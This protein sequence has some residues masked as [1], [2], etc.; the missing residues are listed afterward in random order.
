MN[1]YENTK[2]ESGSIYIPCIYLRRF[3][4]IFTGVFNL[5]LV[6]SRLFSWETNGCVFSTCCPY[7]SRESWA[8]EAA[9]V[10]QRG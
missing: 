2:Y 10:T 9:A 8:A 5:C 1:L 6:F 3:L 7:S 4:N